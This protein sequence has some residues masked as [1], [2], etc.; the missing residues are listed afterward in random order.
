MPK[1]VVVAAGLLLL[2][3]SMVSA[4]SGGW[5]VAADAGS[6]SVGNWPSSGST[7]SS[8]VTSSESQTGYRITGGY[9]FNPYWGLEFSYV[10]LGSAEY[11]YRATVP[12]IPDQASF[13]DLRISARASG[14]AATSTYPFNEQWAAFARLGYM[15]GSLDVDYKTDALF[16]PPNGTNFS[17]KLS[18]GAGVEWSYTASWAFRLGWDRYRQFTGRYGFLGDRDF[19]LATLGVVYRF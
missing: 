8:V 17:W 4:A 12:V 11:H 3:S 15:N 18:Y 19:N 9:Q 10:D 14:M 5:Y 2:H 7:S 1:G 13:V 16:N 6:P